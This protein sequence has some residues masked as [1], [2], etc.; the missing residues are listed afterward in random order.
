M[1][2]EEIFQRKDARPRRRKGK[3]LTDSLCVSA[4]SRLCVK[5]GLRENQQMEDA[6][7]LDKAIRKNL[8]A[9]GYGK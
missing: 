7:N 6:K 8:E 2:S 1:G 3:G 9:L 5:N 4:A